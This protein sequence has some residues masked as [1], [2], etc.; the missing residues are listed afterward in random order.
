MFTKTYSATPK[1]VE[2]N[3]I[4]VEIDACSGIPGF[5]I[6]GLAD[7]AINESRERVSVAMRSCEFELLPKRILVNLSPAHIRKEGVQLDTAIAAA[8][9]VNFG[10]ANVPAHFLNSCCFLGELSLK[11]EIKAIN[12]MLA[13]GIEIEKSQ[14]QNLI[15]PKANAGEASLIKL[16]KDCN[17]NIYQVSN[18]QELKFLLETLCQTETKHPALKEFIVEKP[19]KKSYLAKTESDITESFDDV[20]GQSQAKRGL[21]IAAAGRHHV[22]MIGPPGCGKSMLAKRFKTLLPA[23]PFEEAL[24]TTK[25]YS[26]CRELPEKIM[27]TSPFREPHHSASAIA[28]VGGGS[29]IKPGEVSLAH[30]GVLF[31]DELTEFNKHSIEQLRQILENKEVTI[32]R[33][34]QSLSYPADFIL[35]AACNPCPCGFLGDLEKVCT[36]NKAQI[37]NYIG[38][39]SGPLLDRIDIHIEVSRLKD[40]EI[41]LL[42][43]QQKPCKNNKS[44]QNKVARA[45]NFAKTYSLGSKLDEDCQ[46]L[47]NKAVNKLKLS[48]R[49]HQ[50]IIKVARTIANLDESESI[51]S[52]HLAEAL[53]FR[54][55]NFDKYR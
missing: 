6:V 13:I 45:R 41:K 1:G 30:N 27:L 16:L 47:V 21:E 54:Q 38:K 7:K 37:R 9:M 31:L 12:G 2:A 51:Q 10:Y 5:N 32:N 36:C 20:I 34:K 3:I 40:D 14:I 55:I 28:L 49:S 43:Q 17:L 24:E 4:G 33:I 11:G 42:S 44:L 35:I 15:I 18:L 23:M 39:I 46:E 19:S 53:Q 29:N 26:I 22:L 8:L 52:K 25:I 48:A 50:K